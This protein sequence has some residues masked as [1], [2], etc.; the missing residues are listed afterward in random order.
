L[1][2]VLKPYGE[3]PKTYRFQ[4][5]IPDDKG[6]KQIVLQ[7]TGGND[8]APDEAMPE[9]VTDMFR[10]LAAVYPSDYLVATY[11]APGRGVDVE[12]RRLKML[13]PSVSSLLQPPNAN[14]TGGAA[15]RV[16]LTLKTP[17]V[18][19]GGQRIKVSIKGGR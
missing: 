12:G 6:L 4:V 19:V 17:Y 1:G 7:V 14:Q 16:T 13:P 15:E 5:K 2:V 10:F 9:T 3:D 8:A 11:Q 18:I